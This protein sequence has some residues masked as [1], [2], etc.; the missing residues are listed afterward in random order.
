LRYNQNMRRARFL[1][2]TLL[3]PLL[4]LAV[5]FVA[6]RK[7]KPVYAFADPTVVT[8]AEKAGPVVY[9][10]PE[11]IYPPEA[12]RHRIDG[13]VL[14]RVKIAADG[15][16]DVARVVR[17]PAP[18]HA[19]ALA[20]LSQYQFEPIPAETEIEV[21]FS[22]H[23]PTRSFSSPEP[24][25]RKNPKGAV[26]GTVRVVAAVSPEGKV[27]SVQAV[28]GPQKAIAPAVE[29]V[30]QWTFRPALRNGRPLGGTVVI[31]VPVG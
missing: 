14:F 3:P 10:A 19:A 1:A 24:V 13:S 20:A 11:A 27:F 26:H 8:V 25:E 31:D 15:S 7:P 18:L 22:L 2:N 12:L 6:T 16:V 17:G 29:A 30:K 4:Y 28:S 23:N 21:P 5:V 9:H